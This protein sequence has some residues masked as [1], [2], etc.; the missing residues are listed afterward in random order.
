MLKEI[1]ST[2][3]HQDRASATSKLIAERLNIYPEQALALFKQSK[4]YQDLVNSTGEFDQMLP[5]DLFDLWKNERLTGYPISSSDIE[6]G[7]LK[8]KHFN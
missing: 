1:S 3:F 2:A 7:L 6:N 8:E 5:A 4:L